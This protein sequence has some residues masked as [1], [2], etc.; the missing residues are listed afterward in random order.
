MDKKTLRAKQL[1]TLKEIPTL[2]YEQKCHKIEQRLFRSEEWSDSQVIA[3]TVSKAPEVNTW[4][5]IK[6]GWE[7]G[8]TICVPKCTPQT[9]QL[10]F[11]ALDSFTSLEKVY[12][13]LYEPKP[14]ICESIHKE[15]ID[16]VIVPGLAYTSSGY[17]LGFGG[18]Y[19]DRFLSGYEGYTLS[20]AFTEQI[21]ETLPV[22]PFDIPV[23]KLISEDG[24]LHCE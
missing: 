4:N 8:K 10:S 24:W 22:E 13:G 20:L 2:E 1:E 11:Y 16:A 3:V 7:Q 12:Y 18:G 15:Q 14:T 17:R 9:R 5:V 6:R 21:V 23:A 19:Y